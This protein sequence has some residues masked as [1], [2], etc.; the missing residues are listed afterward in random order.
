MA[1]DPW[2]RAS[3]IHEYSRMISQMAGRSLSDY[4]RLSQPWA[5]QW[6]PPAAGSH[7]K[8]RLGKV[9]GSSAKFCRLQSPC[10]APARDV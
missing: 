9:K 2:E 5:R 6:H 8:W 7:Y 4:G 1:A 3:D 10:T